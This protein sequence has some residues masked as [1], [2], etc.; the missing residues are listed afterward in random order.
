MGGP[1]AA[2][3]KQKKDGEDG[4][5]PVKTCPDCQTIV[6]ASIRLCPSCGYEFPPAPDLSRTASTSAILSSQIR[7]EWLTVTGVTYHHHDKPGSPPS[8][9]SNTLR[10]RQPSRMGVLRIYWYAR[11]KAA[12]WWHKRLPD[13]PVPRTVDEALNS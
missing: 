10:L 12:Q 3:P 8:L 6:H 7:A 1:E 13:L 2:G 4:S 11:Q 9:R 5:A